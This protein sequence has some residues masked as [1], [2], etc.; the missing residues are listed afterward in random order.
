M[1]N[2]EA[3]SPEVTGWAPSSSAG[4]GS[5]RRRARSGLLWR[6][7]SLSWA[8]KT[9]ENRLENH[10]SVW[11]TS[12]AADLQTRGWIYTVWSARVHPKGRFWSRAEPDGAH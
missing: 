1:N 2:G 7:Q 4:Q 6:G 10:H 12:T 3:G 8:A 5:G 9:G 11:T